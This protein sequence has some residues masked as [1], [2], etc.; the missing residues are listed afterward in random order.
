MSEWL[1]EG[2]ERPTSAGK[3]F[4]FEEGDNRIRILSKPVLGWVDWD[5]KNPV[6]TKDKPEHPVNPKKPAKHFWAFVIWDYRD[7]SLKVME[8]T[9][10]TIQDSIIAL[11]NSEDWGVPT[12]YDLNINRTGKEMETKYNVIPFPPKPIT[13]DIADEYATVKIDLEK[14]FSNGDPF[15]QDGAGID[16]S[17]IV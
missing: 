14:L 8:I 4:K 16:V 15:E 2:Y 13:Q 6:R 5:E 12:N 7:K 17:Q 1:P 11:H 3:Y 10:A 9:Q